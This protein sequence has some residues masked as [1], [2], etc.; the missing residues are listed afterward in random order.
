MP[1]SRRLKYPY[2]Q[3]FALPKYKTKVEIF[4]IAHALQS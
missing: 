3:D 2:S 1:Y 4:Q